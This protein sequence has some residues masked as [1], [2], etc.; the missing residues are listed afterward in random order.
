[1]FIS[2]L[3]VRVP[4]AEIFGY[5]GRRR[6][7]KDGNVDRYKLLQVPHSL[8]NQALFY[9]DGKSCLN[10]ERLLPAN[11]F[12]V[13][14]GS[15]NAR[16]LVVRLN[17][18]PQKLML[19]MVFM[20]TLLDVLSKTC[21]ESNLQSVDV[22]LEPPYLADMLELLQR[23]LITS[24]VSPFMRE[25]TFHLLAQILRQLGKTASIERLQFYLEASSNCLNL[26]KSELFKLMEK[27]VSSS[28]ASALEYVLNC[29]F[30]NVK[31]SSYLQSLLE[32]VLAS[33]EV[34]WRL[35]GTEWDSGDSLQQ[36][37]ILWDTFS[38]DVGDQ[39]QVSVSYFFSLRCIARFYYA[40]NSP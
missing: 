13:R 19:C 40:S 15:S 36:K 17:G 33:V 28:R 25:L 21:P 3:R 8:G 22:V 35:K 4:C 2:F 24:T 11:R 16:G 10:P 20:E 37:A 39:A 27:E 34:H 29:N 12:L 32:V 6:L 9:G 30:E 23:F 5:Y 18:I 26:L 1:M 7:T 31:F 38:E 14:L